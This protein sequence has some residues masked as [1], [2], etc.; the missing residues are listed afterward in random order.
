[1]EQ[2]GRLRIK[3]LL[4]KG[5]IH[6]Y[7]ADDPR[8]SEPILLHLLPRETERNHD[9]LERVERGLKSAGDLV[10]ERGRDGGVEYILTDRFHPHQTFLEWLENPQRRLDKPD[11]R[12]QATPDLS[13]MGRWEVPKF[14][15]PPAVPRA[16]PLSSVSGLFPVGT[17]DDFDPLLDTQVMDLGATAAMPSPSPAAPVEFPQV[18]GAEAPAHSPGNF[19]RMFQG[20]PSPPA[21]EPSPREE[22][23]SFT[24]LFRSEP[25][26]GTPP[27]PQG[28][29]P[30]DEKGAL[31]G[32]FT[33]MFQA[34]IGPQTG[35]FKA[36]ASPENPP[37]IES[38]TQPDRGHDPGQFTRMFTSL[39]PEPPPALAV[40]PEI[41]TSPRQEDPC[42]FEKHFEGPLSAANAKDFD[43]DKLKNNPVPAPPP[44][45]KPAGEFT[46]MF[47]KPFASEAP[48]AP[49]PPPAMEGATR[50][51]QAPPKTPGPSWAGGQ[52]PGEYTRMFARPSSSDAPAP[53]GSKPAP[54]PAKPKKASAALIVTLAIL[55]ILAIG[56][57][58]FFAL[59]H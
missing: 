10:L 25:Q 13:K 14:A 59:K 24:R 7:A 54:P 50:V 29:A 47:G 8:R 57:V 31:A 44:A 51:F 15:P 46:Q 56:L 48:R 53:S 11:A 36:P 45:P 52:G 26:P 3:E 42:A 22:P 19:T 9:F 2:F 23:G 5:E 43:F 33:R 12:S 30:S 49:Q 35:G 34:P 38:V 32:E 39:P 4:D 16:E 6:T 28:Q 41:P 40:T 55:F 27:P 17:D 20:Q 58:L 1:M 18:S 37:P 21:L